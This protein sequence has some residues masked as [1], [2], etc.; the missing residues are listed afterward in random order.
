MVLRAVLTMLVVL[1]LVAS[2]ADSA[3]MTTADAIAAVDLGGRTTW[4][5]T[6]GKRASPMTALP[7]ALVFCRM[8]G[9]RWWDR[10]RPTVPQRP[11][12]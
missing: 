12:A 9:R 4:A 6:A 7:P 5:A 1:G 3:G 11:Y 8:F 10:G 2:C